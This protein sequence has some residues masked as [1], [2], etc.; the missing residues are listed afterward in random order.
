[1]KKSHNVSVRWNSIEM[2]E[3]SWM[4]VSSVTQ[5]TCPFECFA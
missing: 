1:M 2:D 4:F 3:K 5:E